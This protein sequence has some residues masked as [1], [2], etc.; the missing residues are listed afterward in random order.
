[1]K[2]FTEADKTRTLRCRGIDLPLKKIPL[3]MGILNITPD[4]FSDGGR[5]SNTDEAVAKALQLV[6][7]GADILDIGGEST[8]PGAMPVPP[9]MELRRVA[10]VLE[11]IVGQVRI[12]ISVDTRRASVA[13]KALA[14]G[15]HMINDVTACSDPE[16]I[17]VLTD[18][19][20][21][22]VIMHMKSDPQ[23][24]QNDPTYRDVVAEVGEYLYDRAE[25]LKSRGLSEDQLIIDPGIGFG[26]RFEDNLELMRN[27]GKLRSLGY[28][29][30]IGGS[31]KRFLGTLLDADTDHRLS[32]SLAVA[33]RCWSED[34]DIVRVHDVKETADLLKVLDAMDN[35]GSFLGG[36]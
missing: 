1:M 24:M 19:K 11:A 23:T 35:P 14:L 28:P 25:F 7:D 18:S 16:M 32:G 27:I 31:R 10:P 26:K 4:S 2:N 33:A 5:F 12:P 21:P 8:R 36:S 20:A 3:V 17:E 22:V 13:A 30:L 34:V 6:S 9:D 15:C 29:V